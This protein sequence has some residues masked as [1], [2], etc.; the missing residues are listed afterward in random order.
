VHHPVAEGSGHTRQFNRLRV[1]PKILKPGANM[2]E[3]LSDTEHHGIEILYPGP[4]LM[5]RYRR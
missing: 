2:I 1:D 5:I 4:A 3:L